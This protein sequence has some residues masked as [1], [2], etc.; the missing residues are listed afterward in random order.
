MLFDDL[1]ERA[2][3]S[4]RQRR[5]RLVRYLVAKG[6]RSIVAPTE[7]LDWLRPLFSTLASPPV[8]F[9]EEWQ[10]L[11]LPPVPALIIRPQVA[12]SPPS[13][14]RSAVRQT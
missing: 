7:E 4:D 13:C 10:P 9:D 12:A 3:G 14:V 6:I 2:T 1:M 11:L 8:F 5:E